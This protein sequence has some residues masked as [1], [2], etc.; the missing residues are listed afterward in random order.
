MTRRRFLAFFGGLLAAVTAAFPVLRRRPAPEIVF[1]MDVGAT[2]LDPNA[3][4]QI[5]C[6]G[7]AE[8]PPGWES[9][10]VGEEKFMI[11]KDHHPLVAYP[12]GRI[13]KLRFET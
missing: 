4:V 6:T 12:D 3:V 5:S 2:R 10:F 1:T 7:Y 8:T 13:E 9:C 11:H